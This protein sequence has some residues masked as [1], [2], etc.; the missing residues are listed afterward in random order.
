ME[1]LR[2]VNLLEVKVFVQYY[3]MVDVIEISV[4]ENINIEEF[5]MEMAK[6]NYV[7]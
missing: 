6:V 4:K 2:E 3:G 1:Y 7:L 5:F